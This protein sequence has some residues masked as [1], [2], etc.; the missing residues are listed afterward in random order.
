[1]CKTDNN[2]TNKQKTEIAFDCKLQYE[3]MRDI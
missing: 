3:I 2:P 1:M